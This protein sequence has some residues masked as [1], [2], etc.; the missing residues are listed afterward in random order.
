MAPKTKTAHKSNNHERF[1]TGIANGT[2]KIRPEYDLEPSDTEAGA[3]QVVPDATELEWEGF[4]EDDGK[5]NGEDAGEN[6]EDESSDDAS[7]DIVLKT[8]KPML[9][10]DAEEEELERLIFGDSTGFKQGI[11][12]F[13]LDQSAG[14]VG[15]ERSDDE[16]E[17]I[18]YENAADQDLFFFDAGPTAAPAGSLV[19][20]KSEQS[21]DD[22]D[23]PAWED[24]DDERLVVSLASVPQLRKLR[25]T[26]VDDMVNGKEYARRLRKQYERLYP[27]PDWA[28]HATGKAKRKRRYTMDDAASDEGSAS[29][30]DI[31]DEDLST[32]PLAKLLKDADLLSRT[33][34]R[35][36][37]RRK[38]QAGTVDIQRLK[39]V[40]K[41]GPVRTALFVETAC[42][43][44]TLIL[45]CNHIS[46]FPPHVS[47]SSLFRSQLYALF[48][49]Y[50]PEPSNTKPTP[51]ISAHEAH[52]AHHNRF[53][54]FSLRLT[55]LSQ[56][57]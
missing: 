50:R 1:S 27:A 37:K 30:M 36:F 29:D 56:R 15:V 42:S 9:P 47:A 10:K 28:I 53:P 19:V 49:P 38:L 46:I 18:D 20:T 55:H 48:A 40:C 33:S 7:V 24:S 51:H 52:T 22:E 23:K 21:E 17:D 8:E 16:E 35:T 25:E 57:S 5:D 11:D 4:D 2:L 41:A 12:A 45:V 3:L 6:E 39:D 34:R 44:N 14:A 32:Q 26:A 13:S 54:S 31:D 43:T